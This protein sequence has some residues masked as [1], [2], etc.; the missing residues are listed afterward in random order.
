MARQ[1]PTTRADYTVFRSLGT[2][3]ADIDLYGHA[4]NA[5]YISWFDT[6]ITGWYVDAGILEIG[7]SP[8]VFIVAETG[9]Q[10]FSEIKFPDA[11][12]IGIR[13]MRLGTSSV[14]YDLGVFV[15]RV[16]SHGVSDNSIDAATS[17]ARGL[18]AHVLTDRVTG[19]PIPIDGARRVALEALTAT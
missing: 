3:W 16:E 2:R 5:A 17:S 10:Y 12:D 19:K 15:N 6:A 13:V 14:T 4:N 7:V 11:L 18:F 1:T 9:A 8:G